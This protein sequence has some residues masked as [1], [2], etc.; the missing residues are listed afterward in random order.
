MRTSMVIYDR[1]ES[2]LVSGEFRSVRE[3][4]SGVQ[5]GYFESSECANKMAI[6]VLYPDGTYSIFERLEGVLARRGC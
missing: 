3:L 2:C 4:D 6:M 5:L 1:K